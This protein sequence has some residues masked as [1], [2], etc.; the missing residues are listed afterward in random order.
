MQLLN[1][2]QIQ[3]PMKVN[4]HKIKNYSILTVK[5][6]G[7]VAGCA[8]FWFIVIEFMWACYYAGIPM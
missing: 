7:I 6:L 4:I 1:I 5:L 8:L 3:N 2:K